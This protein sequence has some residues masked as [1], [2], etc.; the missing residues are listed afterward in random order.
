MV[1]DYTKSM[2]KRLLKLMRMSKDV[3]TVIK[4]IQVYPHWYLQTEQEKKFTKA[5]IEQRFNELNKR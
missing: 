2:N 5:D 3:Q 4:A 1:Y